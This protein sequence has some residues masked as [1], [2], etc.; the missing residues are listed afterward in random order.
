M[1]LINARRTCLPKEVADANFIL[2]YKINPEAVFENGQSERL[3]RDK[4]LGRMFIY[5]RS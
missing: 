2:H 3:D 5:D 4:I 1:P